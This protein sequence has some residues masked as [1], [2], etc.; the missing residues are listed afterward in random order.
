M[1]ALSGTAAI[2][3]LLLPRIPLEGPFFRALSGLAA[4]GEFGLDM[5]DC[6]DRPVLTAAEQETVP[7]A[8]PR[9]RQNLRRLRRRLD[10]LGPLQIEEAKTGRALNDG[11]ETL[12]ALEALGWKGHCGTALAQNTR[13][14]SFTRSMVRQLAP[15][16]DVTVFTLW[17]A[18]TP[19]AAALIVGHL[20]RHYCFK[21]AYNPDFARFSPG[22]IL[23]E[24]VGERLLLQPGFICAD[25]AADDETSFMNRVWPGR[26]KIADVILR[27]ATTHQAVTRV[28]L[29]HQHASR[30][31]RTAAKGV[32]HQLVG[33]RSGL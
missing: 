16:G 4:G 23:A 11:L 2:P 30:A 26:T 12:M 31:L 25:S 17:S 7:T 22:I 9:H 33:R 24:A 1:G 13:T 19:V 3:G 32:Y 5:L 15:H 27:P 10:D 29:A 28:M 6:Y 18:E 14:A 8:S 21:I 20:G